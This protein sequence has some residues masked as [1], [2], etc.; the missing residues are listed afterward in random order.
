M[1]RYTTI[2]SGNRKNSKPQNKKTTKTV[3]ISLLSGGSSFFIK[4]KSNQV[5]TNYNDTNNKIKQNTRLN[6]T[7]F[8]KENKSISYNKYLNNS[9]QKNTY[10]FCSNNNNENNKS[11]LVHK[12]KQSLLSHNKGVYSFVPVKNNNNYGL[13]KNLNSTSLRQNGNE[14][15]ITDVEIL[16]NNINKNLTLH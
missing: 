4:V 10:I 7:Y 6:N 11:T 14:F 16:K 2:T 12:P 1:L 5:A 15:L 13:N 8:Q 3:P 9:Q